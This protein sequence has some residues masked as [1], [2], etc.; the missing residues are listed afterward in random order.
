MKKESDSHVYE[1]KKEANFPGTKEIERSVDG[2]KEAERPLN[3]L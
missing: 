2:I 3:E 1:E